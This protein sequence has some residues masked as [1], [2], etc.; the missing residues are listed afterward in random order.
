MFRKGHTGC[1]GR[2]T[3]WRRQAY[4]GEGRRPPCSY[5]W[6]SSVC[7]G[8]VS[9]SP[10]SFSS[11]RKTCLSPP[12]LPTPMCAPE[13]WGLDPSPRVISGQTPFLL[14]EQRLALCATTPHCET[15]HGVCFPVAFLDFLDATLLN[16]SLQ[17]QEAAASKVTSRSPNPGSFLVRQFRPSILT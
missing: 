15:P 3:G 7:W 11:Q 9:P 14:L 2:E 10:S 8:S 1:S 5:L 13:L 4:V 17:H 12:G 16:Q 6:V